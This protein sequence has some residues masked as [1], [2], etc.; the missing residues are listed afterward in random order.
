[1]VFLTGPR[2]VGKTTLAKSLLPQVVDGKNYLNWDNAQHRKLLTA[3][4]AGHK[5]SILVPDPQMVL[6]EI[7]KYPRWKNSLKG[8]FD[9]NEPNTHWIITGSAALNIY[10]RGQDSLL[11]R[12]FTYHLLPFSVSELLHIKTKETNPTDLLLRESGNANK[13]ELEALRMLERFGGFPEPLFKAQD[14]FLTRWRSTR[15]DRLINQDLR[16]TENL[17]NM[18]LMEQLMMLLP[19][20]ASQLLS[21]NSLREDLEVHFA[22]VKHW[23]DL[24]E[25]IFYGFRL[26]PYS[27]KIQRALKKEAK[28]YLW[29][30]TE[31]D[32]EGLRFENMVAVHLMK[33]VNFANDLGLA[34]LSL[35]YIR[36]KEKREVDFLICDKKKPFVA[37]ECKY[38]DTTPSQHL[39]YFA[40]KLG[41][42][43]AIQCV[44]KLDEPQKQSVNGTV[45]NIVPAA[46]FLAGL[47]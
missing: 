14:S 27:T 24:L 45:I 26:K 19:E 23:L 25:Q 35:F 37:I 46:S 10:R 44:Y 31:I 5:S 36:D 4:F 7:H 34:D 38:Q 13:K 33:L 2:Q 1:M 20:R 12:H 28:W 43:K 9:T 47:I 3:L 29:D 21:L 42:K 22:T 39:A 32:N 11:G 8:L 17:K 41:V 6:D 30:W 15:L 18:G 40:Q 16:S